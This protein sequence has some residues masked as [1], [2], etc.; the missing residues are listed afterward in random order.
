MWEWRAVEK[1]APMSGWMCRRAPGWSPRMCKAA[2]TI[3]SPMRASAGSVVAAATTRKF[4]AVASAGRHHRA[5]APHLCRRAG[6]RRDLVRKAALLE[7]TGDP[8]DPF[9]HGPAD[10]AEDYPT[11]AAGAKDHTGA[12][13]LQRDIVGLSPETLRRGWPRR[14]RSPAPHPY[15]DGPDAL[16]GRF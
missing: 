4:W 6:L 13:E 8:L 9:G 14:A 5:H 10:L 1:S 11:F 15:V 16:L 3:R 12:D 7:C 2:P